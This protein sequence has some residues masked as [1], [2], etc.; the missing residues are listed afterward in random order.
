ML[1]IKDQFLE[2]ALEALKLAENVILK[3]Y[4]QNN[5]TVDYKNDNSPVTQADKE[6]ETVFKNHILKAFPNHK[7]LGEESGG[8]RKAKGYTWVLDPIDGTKYFT[9]GLPYFGTIISLNLDGEFILGISKIILQDQLCYAVKGKGAFLNEK[10]IH[11]SEVKNLEEAYVST[12]SFATFYDN[13]K[14]GHRLVD[15]ARKVRLIRNVGDIPQ[16]HL[17]SQGKFDAYLDAGGDIW[18]H[19]SSK[20][21]IEEAGGIVT[22]LYGEEVTLNTNTLLASNKYLHPQLIELMNS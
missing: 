3:Y 1:Q 21:I 20:A 12:G 19:S 16:M 22:D 18:D 13:L 14:D 10:Q 15:L 2:K 5:F 17:V 4:H 11:V 6:A 8:N 7:F 9:R